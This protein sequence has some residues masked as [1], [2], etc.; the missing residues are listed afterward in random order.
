MEDETQKNLQT[1]TD[2]NDK[3]HVFTTKENSEHSFFEHPETKVDFY[4][5]F[6]IM[7][8]EIEKGSFS[9][10]DISVCI[11]N[12]NIHDKNISSEILKKYHSRII[13]III[14]QPIL[15]IKRNLLLFLTRLSKNSEDELFDCSDEIIAE[16]H[17]QIALNLEILSQN[18]IQE[19]LLLISDL[20]EYFSLFDL[21]NQQN[22]NK[23]LQIHDKMKVFENLTSLFI[24]VVDK[25][26]VLKDYFFQKMIKFMN[27]LTEDP[28]SIKTNPCFIE[29]VICFFNES[30]LQSA[31]EEEFVPISLIY[32]NLINFELNL[33]FLYKQEFEEIFYDR[34]FRS[35]WEKILSL[36]SINKILFNKMEIEDEE[37]QSEVNLEKF[38]K[39]LKRLNYG[40]VK[41]YEGSFFERLLKKVPKT[42]I[43][44]AFGDFTEI[45]QSNESLFDFLLTDEMENSNEWMRKYLKSLSFGF[46]A[47]TNG[48][49]VL[50][51]HKYVNNIAIE[52]LFELIF[53]E[54]KRVL[55]F[56][57]HL[58]FDEGLFEQGKILLDNQLKSLNLLT[59][60]DE[61]KS[62]Q[63][64]RIKI[65]QILETDEFVNIFDYVV[66]NYE[67]FESD[68]CLEI[69]EMLVFSINLSKKIRKNEKVFEETIGK[70]F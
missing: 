50:Q 1:S 29:N 13:R 70:V 49:Q 6:E 10:I 5:A 7:F 33:D 3:E 37:L 21:S 20:L 15:Q 25:K 27:A 52:H 61:N 53:A 42:A 47:F 56:C 58:Q 14:N 51:V 69:V 45:L 4:N 67:L 55:L 18:C 34:L 66:L 54:V 8:N 62:N 44:Q 28:E 16:F 9:S 59:E 36:K 35:F 26:M 30:F 32:V 60:F 48:L 23:I 43:L 40:M 65:S 68:I 31:N 19:S 64:H 46:M 12:M 41:I 39:N 57:Q 38:I 17:K 11:F 24:F 2:P 63:E 22:F